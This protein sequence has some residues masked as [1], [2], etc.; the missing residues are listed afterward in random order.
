MKL[1]IKIKE[2]G[3][4]RPVVT[5]FILVWWTGGAHLSTTASDLRLAGMSGGW[6]ALDRTGR[7]TSS[8]KV[9]VCLDRCSLKAWWATGR[10]VQKRGGRRSC[11]GSLPERS[12]DC[13]FFAA[14]AYLERG[15]PQFALACSCFCSSSCLVSCTDR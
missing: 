11:G 12:L 8:E 14:D 9:L 3:E 1:I 4:I 5:L 6:A 15:S 10:R 2:M 7:H 13:N